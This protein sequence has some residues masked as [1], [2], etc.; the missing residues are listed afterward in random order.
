MKKLSK[1]TESF[2]GDV[3]KRSRGD[4]IRKEDDINLLDIHSLCDYIHNNYKYYIEDD[5]RISNFDDE[6]WLVVCLYENEAGYHKYLFYNGSSVNTQLDVLETIDCLVEIK[7]NYSIGIFENDFG[8]ECVNIYPKDRARV[9]VTNKFFIEILD[10][11]LDRIDAPLEK[12]I[13]K[14]EN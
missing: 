12:Q 8:V 2:W 3:H 6:D 14:R 4:E 7:R 11:I 10:F 5:I 13:E 1:I 9:K